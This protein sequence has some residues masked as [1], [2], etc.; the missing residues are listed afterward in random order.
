MAK[1]NKITPPPP[2]FSRG[3]FPSQQIKKHPFPGREKW[4]AHAAHRPGVGDRGAACH[5]VRV[6]RFD[7]GHILQ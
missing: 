1:L 2:I 4:N 6:M 7:T 5:L 3:I